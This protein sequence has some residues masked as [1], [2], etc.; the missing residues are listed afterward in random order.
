MD[1]QAV[2]QG[3]DIHVFKTTQLDTWALDLTF[4]WT[5]SRDDGQ[6]FGFLG[7]ETR[8]FILDPKMY[9]LYINDDD[10]WRLSS[11]LNKEEVEKLEC[12]NS[13]S[14]C[15]YN[16]SCEDAMKIDLTL[17]MILAGKDGYK[18]M[19]DIPVKN[20][21]DMWKDYTTLGSPDDFK[22]G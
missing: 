10:F 20:S 7:Y 8:Q 18:K 3:H 9:G 5:F 19:F 6:Q 11:F 17:K 21:T 1:R 14:Q 16:G 2:E 13:K 4:D 15:W 22:D 12:S